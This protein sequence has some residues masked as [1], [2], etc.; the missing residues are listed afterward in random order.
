MSLVDGVDDQRDGV[1]PRFGH[2]AMLSRSTASMPDALHFWPLWLAIP[3]PK[4]YRTLTRVFL[5]TLISM[6][7]TAAQRRLRRRPA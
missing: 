5:S 3:R 4:A 2:E 7:P 1:A 6:L